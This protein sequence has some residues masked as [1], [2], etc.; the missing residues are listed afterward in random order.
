M[1]VRVCVLTGA[2][3]RGTRASQC[4]T[5]VLKS[6]YTRSEKSVPSAGSVVAEEAVEKM[7]GGRGS[8]LPRDSSGGSSGRATHT[9]QG[10]YL[11]GREQMKSW[12]SG[13][14]SFH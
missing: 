1:R 9:Q 3:S 10:R 2:E 8:A 5:K 13:D 11:E 4:S 6:L 7:R 14:L 12:G